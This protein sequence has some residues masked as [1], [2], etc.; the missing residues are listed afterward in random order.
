M[1]TRE[2]W[3]DERTGEIAVAGALARR[4]R[5][6]ARRLHIRPDRVIDRAIRA[7]MVDMRKSERRLE[8]R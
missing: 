1:K 7:A 8:A 6:T 4:I 2:L 3:F 5:A